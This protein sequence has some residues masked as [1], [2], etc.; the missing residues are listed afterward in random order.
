[1]CDIIFLR[2]LNQIICFSYSLDH[3]KYFAFYFSYFS[4]LR[5]LLVNSRTS[6]SSFNSVYKEF[7]FQG[8]NFCKFSDFNFVGRISTDSIINHKRKLKLLIKFNYSTNLFSLV[9]SINKIIFIWIFKYSRS[10]YFWDIWGELDIYLYKLLW[11]WSQRRHP[12]RP[13]SWIYNKYW[14]FFG[15]IWRFFTQNI[16]TGEVCIL[17]SHYTKEYLVYRLPFSLSSFNLL[18][19]TKTENIYSVRLENLFTGIVRILWKKQGGLCFF[20]HQVLIVSTVNSF[21]IL[22]VKNCNHSFKN[23]ILLHHYCLI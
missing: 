15:G 12:R 16:L 14:K 18:D 9:H 2:Y 6:F 4:N 3:L 8:W 22:R 20:C 21:K 1:M 11:K 23:F 10:D 13:N 5:G 19:K 17:R 7:K